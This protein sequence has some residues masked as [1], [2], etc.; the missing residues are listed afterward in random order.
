MSGSKTAAQTNRLLSALADRSR[1]RFLKDCELVDLRFATVLCEPGEPIQYAYFPLESFISLVTTLADGSRMEVGIVGDEGM[2]GTSLILGVHRSPQH[3]VV[4]G[5]GAAMRMA[6][7]AFR[8]AL[9]KDDAL[10]RTLER[11]VCVLMRQLAQTT[12]CNHFHLVEKRLARWLLLTRDRAHSNQFRL[13]HEFMA[14][15]L[16]VRRVGIT[17]A[18]RS[19]QAGGLINYARG[20][21][22]ILDGAGLERATCRCYSD[23]RAM[24]ERTLGAPRDA[25]RWR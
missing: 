19:L 13:T 25:L 24:Y 10:R 20:Q 7:P 23:G 21:I 5:A 14:Y 2:F 6:A 11:Y 8:R 18:A 12:A 15:M 3:A 17:R 4:Q 9:V 1:R 16:G 22:E